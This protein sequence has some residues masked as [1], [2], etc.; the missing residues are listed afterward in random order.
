MPEDLGVNSGQRAERGARDDNDGCL[1][2]ANAAL[3]LPP[4]DAAFR[5]S[6]ETWGAALR[7]CALEDVAEHLFTTRQLELRPSPDGSPAHAAWEQAAAAVGGHAD[8]LMRIKQVHGRTVR[9]VRAGAIAPNDIAARPEGDAQISN[10]PDIVLA[11]QVA[12]CVPLLMADRR[13]GAAAAVH[14]GWRG[15]SAG[16]TRAAVEAM[17]REFGTDPRDLTVAIGP[18]IGEC[19][20]EVGDELVDAFRRD[21]ATEAELARWFHRSANGRLRLDLWAANRDQLLATG[22]LDDRTFV[23]RLCTQTHATVFDSYRAAGAAAGRMA[24]VIR[25]PGR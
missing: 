6:D 23:A 14:A 8:R 2:Q 15:T 17:A 9:V 3:T 21:G 19:C 24:A 12:D 10:A 1:G 5:W 13:S 18:S 16:I 4:V 7:C 11:V 22:V 25:T 20:Y